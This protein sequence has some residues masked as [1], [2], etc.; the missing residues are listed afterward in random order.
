MSV[1]G[2][3]FA[4]FIDFSS[5]NHVLCCFRPEL[6]VPSATYHH[7]AVQCIEPDDLLFMHNRHPTIK[8]MTITVFN[9]TLLGNAVSVCSPTLYSG[10]FLS[11]VREDDTYETVVQ[12]LAKISGDAQLY[13]L[14]LAVVTE[15]FTADFVPKPATLVPSHASTSSLPTSEG[16]NQTNGHDQLLGNGRSLET[17]ETVPLIT[18]LHGRTGI[19]P[20]DNGLLFNGLADGERGEDDVNSTTGVV[21]QEADGSIGMDV[22]DDPSLA[23]DMRKD[24]DTLFDDTG[25]ENVLIG[26]QLLL[27]SVDQNADESQKPSPSGQNGGKAVLSIYQRLAQHYPHFVDHSFSEAYDIMLL[28]IQ[29]QRLRSGSNYKTAIP[30]FGIQRSAAEVQSLQSNT[31]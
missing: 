8:S 1:T 10:P 27:D 13:K 26:P 3:M 30:A 24:S 20:T 9:F 22:E 25:K 2:E 11:Y 28:M 23:A 31:K 16:T 6:K 18:E 21:D 19:L 29:S 4:A 5:F 7:V 15:K 17:A 12:R 14:R